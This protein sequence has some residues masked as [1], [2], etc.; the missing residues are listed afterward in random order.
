[1]EDHRLAVH[2]AIVVVDV[3]GFGD[4]RRTNPHQVAVRDGLY[5]AM[6]D[7]FGR[8]GISWDD[9]DHEDRGDGVFVLVPAEVPKALLAESLPPALVTA[10]RAHNDGHPG[11][12][13]IRLRMALH[14]GEVHYDR[15]GVT[16]VAVNLAFRLLDARPLKAALATSSGVLAVIVSSW[17]FDEVVRHSGAAPGYRPAE[18]AV[19]ET[20]TTGWICLPD[21][22]RISVKETQATSWICP[23]DA[24][25]PARAQAVTPSLPLVVPRQLPAAIS[26]FAGRKAELDTL[27]DVLAG[28]IEAGGAIVI[29]AVD[30]TAGIGKTA[31]AVKWAHS[32]ADRFPDGQLY[33]NLRGFDPV[34]PPLASGDAVR[35]FLDAFEVPGDRIPAN[36]EAQAALYRS[37]LA[38]KRVLVVLDNARDAEQVRPLLPGSAG[39]LV[40]V[41]SRPRLTGLIASEGAYP[42]TVNLMP[43]AD[44]RQLLARRVGPRRVEAEPEAVTDII[45]RCAQLPLALSIVAARAASHPTF[46][47]AAMAAELREARGSLEAFADGDRAADLRAVF[48]WSYQRLSTS[49]AR[50]FRLL[51]LYPGTAIGAPAAASLAGLSLLQG[52]IL[53]GELARAHLVEEQAPGRFSFHDLLRAYATEL[54]HADESEAERHAAVHRVLDHYLLTAHAA[55]RFLHPRMDFTMKTPFMAGVV[56]ETFASPEEAW[57]WFEI[58]Y[59]VFMDLIRLAVAR[60]WD[61]HAWQFPVVL[62]EYLDRRGHRHDC[63]E[64]LRTALAAAQNMD[65][66]QG[67]AY[68]H[69]GLGRV[70]HWFGDFEE[71]GEHLKRALHFCEK[72]DEEALKAHAHVEYSHVFEHQ[73]RLTHA[74]DHAQCALNLAR[75]VGSRRAEARALFFSGKYHALLGDYGQALNCSQQALILNRK[76]GDRRSEGY[77]LNG[78]GYAYQGLGQYEQAIAY[79]EQELAL[80]SELADR[81]SLAVTFNLLGDTH[82]A[83]GNEDAAGHAWQQALRILDEFG[84]VDIGHVRAEQ[85]RAKLGSLPGAMPQSISLWSG[86]VI[87]TS[88]YPSDCKRTAAGFL[89]VFDWFDILICLI[90]R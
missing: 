54:A 10:L 49:A 48:S 42:L 71:A 32:V 62:E 18:V 19:K 58:E 33:V 60:G 50:V 30:G 2:R 41:T 47:M 8:A 66:W 5:R 28:R 12:E 38:G 70:F 14:A 34:G 7:A 4:Q 68:A 22:V 55:A 44:A 24:L 21:A 78:I 82:Q 65:N 46:S 85:L 1:M 37:L 13:R 52:R 16:A 43:V 36:P 76:I 59:P 40:V 25:F 90:C 3:E 39:S 45:A 35:G 80:Q 64:A 51:G 53:L 69:Y 87:V 27:T 20:T 79:Y 86:R 11:P 6:Q 57:A 61:T 88:C 63:R 83:A 84:T 73:K 31:I 72:V 89:R 74:L 29:S 23:P 75:A 77:T 81:Y 56:P 9:C 15:H 26:G 67:Q 17:F